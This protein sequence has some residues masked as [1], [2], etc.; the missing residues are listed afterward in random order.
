M[1]GVNVFAATDCLWKDQ[2]R[3]HGT[4][5]LADTPRPCRVHCADAKAFVHEG[6]RRALS[7]TGRLQR[8]GSQF[9]NDGVAGNGKQVP[10]GILCPTPPR[11]G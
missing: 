3:G 7:K 5:F 2:Y 4:G 6:V 1:R 8:G 11:H 10:D 9:V